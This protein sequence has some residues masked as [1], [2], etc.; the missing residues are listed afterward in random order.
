M[1][2]TGHRNIGIFGGSFNP[3]HLGHTALA[4]QIRREANLDEVWLMVSPQNPLK[5]VDTLLS[6]QLRFQMARLA[7]HGEDGIRAVSYELHLPRPSY[8]WN[9]L[10][11]LSNLFPLYRFSLIIGADN[12][13]TFKHWRH[14]DDIISNY[15][16]LVYPRQGYDVDTNSLPTTVRM[17]QMPLYNISSTMVRSCVQQGNDIR[18]LVSPAIVPLVKRLYLEK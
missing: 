16:I 7:L 18:E 15:D 6:D 14:S 3:I 11:H 9:T 2:A 8:T 12:W 1:A 4:R 10:Q 5:P 13:H 17:L